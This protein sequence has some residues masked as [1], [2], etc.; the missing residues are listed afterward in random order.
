MKVQGIRRDSRDLG[1]VSWCGWVSPVNLLRAMQGRL[2]PKLQT[3]DAMQ[4]R[5]RVITSAY[6]AT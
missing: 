3:I 4:G 6:P 2:Q 5:L 1:L